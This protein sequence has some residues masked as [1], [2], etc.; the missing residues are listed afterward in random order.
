MASFFD[1]LHERRPDE[2]MLRLGIDN[3]A[4][5]AHPLRIQCKVCSGVGDG[6]AAATSW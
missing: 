2:G 1:A 3:I 6:K 5:T 4:L